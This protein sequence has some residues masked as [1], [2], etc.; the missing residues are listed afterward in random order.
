MKAETFT[1]SVQTTFLPKNN[2][3]DFYVRGGVRSS[4]GRIF[5]SKPNGP[6]PP[7]EPLAVAEGK[8]SNWLGSNVYEVGQTVEGRTAEY[9]G[10]VEPVTYRYRFQFKATGTDSWVNGSW[11]NTTNAKN[12]VSCTLTEAGQVKMQS[13]ARDSS[14][15]VVQLNSV[16]GIKNVT[17]PPP[18]P[19][20]TTIGEVSVTVNDIDYTNDTLT[21][22]IN[23]PIYVV[24]SITGDADTTY[25]WKARNDYPLL[26]GSQTASTVLTFPEE[27]LATVTCDLIAS[28]ASDNPKTI[29]LNMFIVDALD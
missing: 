14:D 28:S 17:E 27:G 5:G 23:D 3:L 1:P 12:P 25:T 11:T 8:G 9:V 15:P 19:P 16:A 2:Q 10:G 22:L 6:I 20:P 13:Q 21:V 24:V 29:I 18:P 4:K 7:A 26:V